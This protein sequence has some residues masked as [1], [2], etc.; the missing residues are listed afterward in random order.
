MIR[1]PP[2]STLFPYTTLFRSLRC[3]RCAAKLTVH[4]TGSRHDVARYACHRAWLDKGQARCISFGGQRVDERIAAEVL[5]IVQP[6]AI[7]AATLAYQEEAAQQDEV[8]DALQR[9]LQA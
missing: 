1:R 2:R 5:R 8:E 6:A 9:D 4:Y 3:R 7:E